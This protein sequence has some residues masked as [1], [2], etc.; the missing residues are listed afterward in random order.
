MK[1]IVVILLVLILCGCNNKSELFK[2]QKVNNEEMIALMNENKYIIIDVRTNEEFD[3]KHI[4]GA[5]NI[6]YDEL[7]S[8]VLP[9]T[10]ILFVYCASGRRS[11]IASNTLI[12]LGYKTYDLGSIDNIDLEIE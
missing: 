7:A 5:I 2:Y 9:Q 8:S 12:D 10:E 11:E 1:K 3:L 4:K 6:P